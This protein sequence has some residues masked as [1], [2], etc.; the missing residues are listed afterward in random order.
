MR[1]RGPH[2]LPL[3][4]PA[5][6]L[7]L[8]AAGG[9]GGGCA[10]GSQQ[11]RLFRGRR[12]VRG[13]PRLHRERCGQVLARRLLRDLLPGHVVRVDQVAQL[14]GQREPVRLA[15]PQARRHGLAAAWPVAGVMGHS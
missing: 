11:L 4:P 12:V 15:A 3:Q 7:I 10:C 5:T 8:P 14:R 6:V 9:D 13:D 2:L 1:E